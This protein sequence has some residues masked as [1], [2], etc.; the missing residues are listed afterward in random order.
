MTICFCIILSLLFSFPNL[1]FYG[2]LNFILFF[3]TPQNTYLNMF[4]QLML[5]PSLY[6]GICSFSHASLEPFFKKCIIYFKL[7]F[8]VTFGECI[9]QE[10][11]TSTFETQLVNSLLS[12]FQNTRIQLE[13]FYFREHDLARNNSRK[14][15]PSTS[16]L[17]M[18]YFIFA[19]FP[20]EY[21]NHTVIYNCHVLLM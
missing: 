6:F 1:V 17:F 2:T 3:C 10:M 18:N 9:L 5:R 14:A 7:T 16:I 19:I 15:F 21:I 11:Q 12:D 20:L 8:H 4:P 13:Q